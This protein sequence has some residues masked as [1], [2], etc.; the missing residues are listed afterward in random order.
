MGEYAG[1][2]GILWEQLDAD[3]KRQVIILVNGAGGKRQAQAIAYGRV[4]Y[5]V[6]RSKRSFEIVK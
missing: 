1:V 6:R 5:Y 2:A 3:W 4:S